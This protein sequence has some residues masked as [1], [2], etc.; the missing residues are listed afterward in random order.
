VR[1]DARN[2]G[3]QLRRRRFG[4]RLDFR[5]RFGDGPRAAG[6]AVPDHADIRLCREVEGAKHPLFVFVTQVLQPLLGE[7]VDLLD[8]GLGAHGE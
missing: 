4:D 1:K 6:A 5:R 7:G 3:F 2:L 8:G